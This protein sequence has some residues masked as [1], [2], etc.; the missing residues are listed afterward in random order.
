MRV[1]KYVNFRKRDTLQEPND[2]EL[3]S[4]PCRSGNKPRLRM[5]TGKAHKMSRS[6][7][8]TCK[9]TYYIKN[10]WEHFNQVLKTM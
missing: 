3:F 6:H 10:C 8:K 9:S 4:F 5:D 7:E 2:E 1:L